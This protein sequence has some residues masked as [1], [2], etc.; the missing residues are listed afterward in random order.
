MP[1]AF[2]S[3]PS[4]IRRARPPTAHSGVTDIAQHP[5]R[6]GA[7]ADRSACVFCIHGEVT[8]PEVDVFDREAVFIDRVLL[9]AGARLSGAQDRAR[10]Y[11]DQ[12]G[13]R[14]RRR[15]PGQCRRDDHSAAPPPQP[16]RPVP[17]RPSSPRLLPAGGEAG[18]ASAGGAQG[19]GQRLTEIFPRHRHRAACA[20]SQGIGLRLRRHLQR[21]LRARKLC[22]G[23]RRGRGARQV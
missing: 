1:K 22:A 13:R 6:A 8:D 23:V 3:R 11:H 4:S 21:A 9:A 5:R 19:G 20:R 2:G 10:A 18:G 16:Q 14:V 15:C 17:G 7:D 12:T